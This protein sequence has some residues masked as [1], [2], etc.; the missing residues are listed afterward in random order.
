VSTSIGAD[1]LTDPS[2]AS[3]DDATVG[4]TLAPTGARPVEVARGVELGRYLILHELGQ[5]ATGHVWAAYDGDLDRKVAIKVVAEPIGDDPERRKRLLG[6]A[7]A[8]AKIRHPN[9]VLV[10]DVGTHA[11]R[12]YIAMEFVEGTTLGRWSKGDPAPSFAARLDA[13]IA[14]GRGLAEAHRA[15]LVHRDF[16]PDNVLIAPQGAPQGNRIRVADFGLAQSAE[17]AQGTSAIAGTPAYMSPEHH[18][19]GAID[20]RSDQFSYCVA[21]FELLAGRRPFAGDSLAQLARATLGGEIDLAAAATIPARIRRVILRGLATKPDD[22][23]ASMDELVAALER[24]RRPRW[25]L[26]LGLPAALLAAGLAWTIGRPDAAAGPCTQGTALAQA[27]WS[28]AQ[29]E[30]VR[31]VDGEL[32]HESATAAET[33][34]THALDSYESAWATLHDDICR[35]DAAED[36][37]DGTISAHAACVDDRLAAFAGFVDHVTSHE[38]PAERVDGLLDTLPP[39]AECDGDRASAWE[40]FPTDPEL[41]ARVTRLRE[42]LREIARKFKAADIEGAQPELIALVDEARAIDFPHTTATA[43]M[44]LAWVED[45][46]GRVDEARRHYDE[47]LHVA[48]A[49]GH[50]WVAASVVANMVAQMAKNPGMDADADRWVELAG[51]LLERDGGDDQLLATVYAAFASVLYN[52]GDLHGALA[53]HRSVEAL[54]RRAGAGEHVLA[55][56]WLS[57]AS[58]LAMLHRTDEAWELASRAAPVLDAYYVADHPAAIRAVHVIGGIAEKRGDVDTAIALLE[59]AVRR[60]STAKSSGRRT[61]TITYNL[62]NMYTKR[63]RLGEAVETL[64]LSRRLWPVANDAFSNAQYEELE[65]RIASARGDYV[66]QLRH[67]DRSLELYKGASGNRDATVA[68]AQLL[69][70]DALGR[71]RRWDEVLTELDALWPEWHDA[72]FFVVG[73]TVNGMLAAHERGD[74]LATALWLARSEARPVMVVEDPILLRFA[75]A[76]ARGDRS[77]AGLRADRDRLVATN[78]PDDA[79]AKEI[80]AWIA[81]AL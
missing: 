18:G 57:E 58:L 52:R 55:E 66:D 44:R 72:P 3:S 60:S 76:I 48:I 16:K 25:L 4:G 5:G 22:R 38:I 47:A 28:E 8:M 77:D 59:E 31:I 75:H 36:T 40:P 1:E 71:L 50:D 33:R 43:L 9:V 17:H 26:V 10:H 42:R 81:G 45:E 19:V 14:A 21:L 41:A 80:E 2:D 67:L 70:T 29:R 12:L 53:R 6:E 32:S 27:T 78:H 49:A 20:A 34:L 11:G 51:A 56:T 46:L 54:K 73:Y 7:Q 35:R 79:W 74:A 64:A 13:M 63:G 30:R 15:G 65:S 24:A 68:R 39:L 37:R 61:S 23:H 62:A 69:R